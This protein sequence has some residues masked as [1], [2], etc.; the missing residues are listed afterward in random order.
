MFNFKKRI[1]LKIL[2]QLVVVVTSLSCASG[3]SGANP[4]LVY[5]PYGMSNYAKRLKDRMVNLTE[6]EG[7][8][9]KEIAGANNH[10]KLFEAI[11]GLIG[12]NGAY[13]PQKATSYL[14][15][16]IVMN[17]NEA[18]SVKKEVYGKV[19]DN[20]AN[21]MWGEVRGI[22]SKLGV[23]SGEGYGVLG[24]YKFELDNGVDINPFIRWDR[25]SMS[26]EVEGERNI[27]I[28]KSVGIGI[29]G[30]VERDRTYG[31]I[32]VMYSR[33]EVETERKEMK[34][35]KENEA[36]GK[37]EIG[38]WLLGVEGGYN[39]WIVKEEV[40]RGIKIEPH[41][42]AT[43]ISINRGANE[44]VGG[45]NALNVREMN[46]D[47]VIG[48]IGVGIEGKVNRKLKLKGGVGA[49]IVL[50]GGEGEVLGRGDSESGYYGQEDAR[51]V[52]YYG[53]YGAPVESKS[54]GEGRIR[55]GGNVGGDYRV[56]KDV[57]VGA[58]ISIEKGIDGSYR[59]IKGN[60]GIGV[61]IGTGRGAKAEGRALK[62][63]VERLA[64]KAGEEVED[65]KEDARSMV[66]KKSKEMEKKKKELIKKANA[67]RAKSM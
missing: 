28:E 52:K 62:R 10:A 47:R 67:K 39:W 65:K 36:K 15:N 27:G 57:K 20:V 32:G 61:K 29:V 18:N 22:D 50:V 13:V 2:I 44:E 14:A 58:N 4:K 63:V 49:D 33:G 5:D 40:G 11:M 12:K 35:G 38:T 42:G 7:N 53:T 6:K 17:A 24:G 37:T 56:T 16:M 21:G 23:F 55:I 43:L 41:I 1:I 3:N 60:M 31:K 66:K 25:T 30:K 45:A 8:P 54:I 46:M 51:G 9:N 19:G 26:Q 64:I 34:G 59:E 48:D